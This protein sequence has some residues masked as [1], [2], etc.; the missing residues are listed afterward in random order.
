MTLKSWMVEVASGAS[1]ARGA[2]PAVRCWSWS[3]GCTTLCVG[4]ICAGGNQIVAG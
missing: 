2:D 3:L 4:F 1:G